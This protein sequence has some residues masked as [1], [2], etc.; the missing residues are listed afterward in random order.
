[1]SSAGSD[2]QA[3]L[4]QARASLGVRDYQAARRLFEQAL[5]A[6]QGTAADYNDY[7][8]VL[9]NLR[10]LDLARQAFASATA[11]D[12]GF[13]EAHNN[14]GHV[15]RAQNQAQAAAEQF[16][17]AVGL[18]PDYALAWEN[19]GTVLALTGEYDAAIEALEKALA[20][21]PGSADAHLNIAGLYRVRNADDAALAHVRKAL[22]LAPG[23]VDGHIQLA[24]LLEARGEL[25]AAA[26]S[27]T[28][29][30][31]L[32]PL[33]PQALAG[34]ADLLDKTG[35]YD[36]GLALLQPGLA[37]HPDDL[38]LVVARARLLR[39]KGA[40]D[41]AL[42]ELAAIR[43]RCPQQIGKL[44]RYF[45][46]LGDIYDERGEYEAAFDAYRQANEL[47][48]ET[49]EPGDIVAAVDALVGVFSAEFFA[50]AQQS[51]NNSERPVFIV[52]MP[53]SGTSLV[54]QIL[55]SHPEVYG[56]GELRLIVDQVRALGTDRAV[57]G[58]YPECVPGL[59]AARLAGLADA[60]LEELNK[61]DAS[62]ARVTDKMPHN[63]LH[64]GLIRLLF[65]A[66][67]IIHCRR[68]PLDTLLSCYFQD[69]ASTAMAFSN[70]LEHLALYFRQ[71][72]RL[73]DHW[74]SVLPGGVFEVRYE[75]LVADPRERSAELLN[76][77]GLEWMPEVLEFYRSKRV[78]KTASH[79]Q[80]RQPVY[81][82]SVAR[83]ERYAGQLGRLRKILT[84]V[85]GA[86][87]L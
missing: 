69:F 35:E 16:R 62:A 81:T 40:A 18:R 44:P 59:G 19:L 61:M 87:D 84:P 68:H 39:R 47:K 51:G 76:Y 46:T 85:L 12:P 42:S 74:A 4:S 10:E 17:T 20:L 34:L 3:I 38:G 49:F 2:R 73:M 71:Y 36:Q 30:L 80:V 5:A 83:H 56:A 15:L 7:G 14:L 60:Y 86:A 53:R 70:N 50:G 31:D 28:T 6:D 64:L 37:E 57:A 58:Y 82:R 63:F 1:M 78:V 21:R 72:Q 9:N 32:H 52:G 55:A 33:H 22:Q 66:A 26:A 29:A 27:Y 41:Q 79:A 48:E 43:S 54:E 75:A 24:S 67:R 23:L 45:F 25:E 65:P 8:R 77:L 13:A 11:L